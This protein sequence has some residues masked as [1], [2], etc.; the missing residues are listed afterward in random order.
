MLTR[1]STRENLPASVQALH[2]CTKAKKQRGQ[3]AIIA[4]VLA[5]II[6]AILLVLVVTHF[7]D[8]K[9]SA[10]GASS[11]SDVV[12]MIGKAQK[13]YH[14]V[15]TGYT[16]VTVATLIGNG[17]VPSD[18][19]NGAAI[20]SPYGTPITVAVATIYTAGDGIAYTVQ[21]PP[22]SCSD[23]ATSM[24]GSVAKMTVAGTTIIDTTA[25]T[26]L[27]PATLSTACTG[28]GA[29]IPVVLTATR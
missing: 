7:S 18:M 3:A 24:A 10:G 6:F 19:I 2:I 29:Q 8:A 25:G 1:Y 26:A 17:D 4:A 21:V 28:T 11:T 20:T 15:S 13:T 22:A 16:G 5:L 27:S 9:N 14:S 23:F 12:Q